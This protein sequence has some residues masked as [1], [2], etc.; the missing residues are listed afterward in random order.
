MIDNDKIEKDQNNDNDA[1]TV[2][3]Y[4]YNGDAVKLVLK[5][6]EKLLLPVLLEYSPYFIRGAAIEDEKIEL[7]RNVS[8]VFACKKKAFSSISR[9]PKSKKQLSDYLR[10]NKFSADI[11]KNTITDMEKEG[12]LDDADYARRYA[13]YFSA[14]KNA[15]V[16]LLRAELA[17]KGIDRNT[18]EEALRTTGLLEDNIDDAYNAAIKKARSLEGKP[19]AYEKVSAFLQM[20]GFSFKTVRAVTDKLRKEGLLTRNDI[21]E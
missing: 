11:I 20:R 8:A 12:Y 2:E 7:F 16:Q 15:G 18:A 9:G 6:G 13:E 1:N 17:R 3:S 19:R 21:Y 4:S 5:S 10:K 14:R